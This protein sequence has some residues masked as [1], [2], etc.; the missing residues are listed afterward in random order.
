MFVKE[1][2]EHEKALIVLNFT[3]K[4]QKWTAPDAKELG[5][6][7]VSEVSLARIMSTH[8]GTAAE[9]LAALEGRVYLVGCK[10]NN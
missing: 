10:L 3:T 9:E 4:D 7:A 8:A 5:L 1:S 6:P 2:S